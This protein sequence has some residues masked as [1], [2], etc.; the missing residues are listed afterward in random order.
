MSENLSRATGSPPARDGR[1]RR[2][3][4]L[5][6][7]TSSNVCSTTVDSVIDALRVERPFDGVV[8]LPL[9]NLL[10]A[11]HVGTVAVLRDSHEPFTG[12][13]LHLTRMI[14]KGCC[15]IDGVHATPPMT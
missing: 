13:L 9:E 3:D 6:V 4:T 7:L 2:F 11:E 1:L 12:S 5:Y 8:H 10:R 14:A 15:G